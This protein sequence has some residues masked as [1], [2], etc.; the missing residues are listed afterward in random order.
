MSLTDLERFTAA[1]DYPGLLDETAV[2][3][4]LTA[5]IA[6]LGVK[7]NV[8]RLPAGWRVEDHPS[9]MCAVDWILDD[10][11]KRNPEVRD[12]AREALAALDAGGKEAE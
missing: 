4:H 10:W 7:R 3:G 1:C 2:T 11:V 5:Y 8:V 12:A 6:A 9:L